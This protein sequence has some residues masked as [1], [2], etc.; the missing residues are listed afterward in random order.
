MP[1][2]ILMSLYKLFS[3]TAYFM[4]NFVYILIEMIVGLVIAKIFVTEKWASIWNVKAKFCLQVSQIKE[5]LCLVY[6]FPSDV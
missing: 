6:S 4:C 5:L 3:L 2:D 1:D